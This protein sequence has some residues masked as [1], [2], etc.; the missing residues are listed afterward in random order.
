MSDLFGITKRHWLGHQQLPADERA[1]V[2]ALLR[3]LDFH[4]SELAIVDKELAP[5]GAE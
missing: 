1:R 2:Q 5:R 4:G 3:Q